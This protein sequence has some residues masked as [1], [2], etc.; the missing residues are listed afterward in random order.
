ME[1][2]VRDI[3]TYGT[4]ANNIFISAASTFFS[5][6]AAL[7]VLLTEQNERQSWTF[8]SERRLARLYFH[9]TWKLFLATSIV[10]YPMKK[11]SMALEMPS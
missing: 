9:I 1:R 11:I 3:R 8:L 4:N 7:T 2:I 10:F 6:A 5:S